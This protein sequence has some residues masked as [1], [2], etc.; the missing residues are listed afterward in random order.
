MKRLLLIILLFLSSSP[1]YAEWVEVE[2]GDK[3]TAYVDTETIRRKGNLV[4]IWVLDDFKTVRTASGKSYLSIKSLD[5]Y[6]C[7][8][9]QI[10]NLAL[11]AYSGQMGTGEIVEPLSDDPSKWTPIIPGSVGQ[12]KWKLVCKQK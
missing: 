11:Y 7:A 3:F 9:A 2:G 1:A 10:R 5:E 8:E 6:D 4:K 12:T